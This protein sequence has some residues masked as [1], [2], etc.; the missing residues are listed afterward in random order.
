MN[1][2]YK[3]ARD[4]ITPEVDHVWLDDQ[5]ESENVRDFMRLLG[6]QYVERIKLLRAAASGSSPTSRST[7]RSRG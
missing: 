6:P 3:T 2:V 4:F 5:T 7:K 1:L